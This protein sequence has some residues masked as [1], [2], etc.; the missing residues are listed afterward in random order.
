VIYID[1]HPTSTAGK[2]V[3]AFAM[4]S[5]VLVIAF[6]VGVFSDLWSE[7]LKEVKGFNDLF[8][9]DTDNNDDDQVRQK[10]SDDNIPPQL[11]SSDLK[12]S[13]DLRR[14]SKDSGY[15]VMEKEDLNDIV[16]SL[17]TIRQEQRRIKRLL[18]KYYVMKDD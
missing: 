10:S 2:W 15:V 6:P 4:L 14:L 11:P 12:N 7:E 5:G 1:Y 8:D 9:N 13:V 18:K 17:H 16:A 3:A